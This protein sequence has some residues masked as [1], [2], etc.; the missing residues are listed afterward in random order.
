[1]TLNREG[2][3]A[4]PYTSVSSFFIISLFF[5]VNFYCSLIKAFLRSTYHY[6]AMSDTLSALSLLGHLCVYFDS[7]SWSGGVSNTSC[8]HLTPSSASLL[9]EATDIVWVDV[10]KYF[11]ISGSSWI[12]GELLTNDIKWDGGE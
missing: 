1:M 5:E 10:G 2:I 11:W 6:F 12:Q 8:L 7:H 4:K 3:D 9:S